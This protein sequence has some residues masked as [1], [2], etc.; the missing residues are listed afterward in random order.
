LRA[1]GREKRIVVSENANPGVN[2]RRVTAGRLR[3]AFPLPPFA[4]LQQGLAL[5]TA[6][7]RKALGL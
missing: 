1:A 4:D 2:V 6:W 7:Y 3:A 5:T